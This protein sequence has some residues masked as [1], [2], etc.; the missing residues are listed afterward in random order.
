MS[1]ESYRLEQRRVNEEAHEARIASFERSEAAAKARREIA[2]KA[3]PSPEVE[4]ETSEQPETGEP[5]M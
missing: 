5:E 2:P 4:A 3:K 1:S